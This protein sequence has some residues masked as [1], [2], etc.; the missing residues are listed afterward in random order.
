MQLVI[1]QY[2][3]E[4]AEGLA[5]FLAHLDPVL[6]D[7]SNEQIAVDIFKCPGSDPNL[8]DL[9]IRIQVNPN[10]SSA[11]YLGPEVYCA[12]GLK[13][14]FVSRILHEADLL[15]VYL[16]HERK[17]K[18]TVSKLTITEEGAVIG[19][20]KLSVEKYTG[21]FETALTHLE[22]DYD[23][24]CYHPRFHDHA[25]ELEQACDGS[26]A[27]KYA[28]EVEFGLGGCRPDAFPYTGQ[29]LREQFEKREKIWVQ[30]GKL[31]HKA[32]VRFVGGLEYYLY[33]YFIVLSVN[34]EL[35]F[36][37]SPTM[38]S[39]HLSDRSWS[40]DRKSSIALTF[41]LFAPQET[42]ERGPKQS[43]SFELSEAGIV[44]SDL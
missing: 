28:F 26:N 29:L 43:L 34:G 44:S 35:H 30:S 23:I 5:H 1:E 25:D 10:D 21:P 20:K 2:H 33:Q 15:E 32:F 31:K 37:L 14:L 22:L 8:R 19:S 6:H 13:G 27:F 12:K 42:H 3:Y 17:G 18:P 40:S 7:F 4:E 11:F 9:F 16:D 36:Y 39:I 38:R 24:I 41:E